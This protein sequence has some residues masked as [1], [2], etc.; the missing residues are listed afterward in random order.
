L[1]DTFS[2]DRFLK[3]T[4]VSCLKGLGTNALALTFHWLF[5]KFEVAPGSLLTG[6]RFFFELILEIFDC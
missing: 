4:S 1:A 6:S 5:G 3:S 2:G